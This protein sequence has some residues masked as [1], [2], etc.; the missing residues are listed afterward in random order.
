MK[1]KL[2]C[3]FVKKDNL[4]T[5]IEYL[6]NNFPIRNYKI[7]VLTLTQNPLEYAC[8]YGIEGGNILNNVDNTILVHKKKETNT[9]YTINALNKAVKIHNSGSLD[10]NFKLNWDFYKNSILL[11]DSNQLKVLKTKIYKVVESSD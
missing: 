5:L 1:N 10:F 2:F 3:S 7:F 6:I 11:T 8:T 4:Q 9:I